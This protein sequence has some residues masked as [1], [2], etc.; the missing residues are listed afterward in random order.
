MNY[1]ETLAYW[2]FRLNGFFLIRNFVLHRGGKGEDVRG[3][4]DTD[5]LGVRAPH[6]SEDINGKEVKCD[7][8]LEELLKTFDR[9]STIGVVVEVKSGQADNDAI[10]KSFNSE[11]MKVALRRLG[12]V[13]RGDKSEDAAIAA[14]QTASR[15]SGDG[16]TLVKVLVHASA[17]TTNA[18]CHF[19]T[20]ESVERF[21][22]DRFYEHKV[23]K[24]ADRLFFPDE[25]I[26]Y[27]AWKAKV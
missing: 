7:S 1:A 20:L 25:L 3:T 15:Y 23:R 27:L 12:F 16:W 17:P 9:P 13:K 4:A 11:R 21:I 10:G 14:L 5:L 19:L 26:Q 2:Y 24:C 8:W 22:Q 18:G 6:V